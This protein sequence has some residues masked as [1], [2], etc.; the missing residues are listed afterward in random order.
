MV[1]ELVGRAVRG[2]ERTRRVAGGDRGCGGYGENEVVLGIGGVVGGRKGLEVIG[3]LGGSG[4]YEGA[5][6]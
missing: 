4:K 6:G 3:V 1:P 5:L 2:Q